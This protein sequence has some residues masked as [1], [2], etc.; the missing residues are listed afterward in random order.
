MV[1]QG[2]DMAAVG[3]IARRVQLLDIKV[4]SIAADRKA[5]GGSSLEPDLSMSF[6]GKLLAKEQ[7]V[8]EC[9][10]TLKATS[11]QK[12]VASVRVVIL[13]VYR[14]E[15]DD[16]VEPADVPHFA[17]A[18]GAYHSWPFAREL[19]YS[20]TT[21]LGLPPYTLPVLV[22]RPPKPSAAVKAPTKRPRKL[23]VT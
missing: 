8:V 4:I 19:I 23:A 16:P 18:N 21:R 14:I 7:L 22:F 17:N 6:N 11:Q 9:V 10:Y 12:E 1:H 13:M 2:P 20:L 3:R 5:G 15:N